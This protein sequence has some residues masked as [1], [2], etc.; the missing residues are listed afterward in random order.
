MTTPHRASPECFTAATDEGIVA[1]LALVQTGMGTEAL[2]VLV[3]VPPKLPC[4]HGW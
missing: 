1:W 2:L 3:I 4:S